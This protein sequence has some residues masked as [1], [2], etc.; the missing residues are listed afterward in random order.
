ML[1]SPPCKQKTSLRKKVSCLKVIK[2][3]STMHVLPLAG[4]IKV[5]IVLKNYHI[6]GKLHC[7]WI[8]SVF[9]NPLPSPDAPEVAVFQN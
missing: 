9:L 7:V 5:L 4:S 8:E 3:I 1:A 6:L 2:L